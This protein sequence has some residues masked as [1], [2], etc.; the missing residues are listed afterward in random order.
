MSCGH[1]GRIARCD[2][3][4]PWPSGVHPGGGLTAAAVRSPRNIAVIDN[5]GQST[6]ADVAE[7]TTRIAS[8][9]TT[10]GFTAN[11]KLALLAR[12]HS[13]MVECMVAASKL[14]ADLVLLNT[15]LAAHPIEEI[16]R[17]HAVDAIF[18]DDEFEQQV[19]YLPAEI[20]RIATRPAPAVPQRRS[21]DDLIAAGTDNGPLTPPKQPGK[22]VVLT[23]GTTGTPKGARRPHHKASARSPRCCRGCRCVTT[24]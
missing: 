9:L 16:V 15:G 1:P 24:R 20:P 6:Y 7:R 23:S 12:N 11:S 13:A 8:G 2:N 21:I 10:V 4:T 14:G 3:S 18:V 19:R 17:R 5:L 22:L